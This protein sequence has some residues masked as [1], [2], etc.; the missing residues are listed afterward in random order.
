MQQTVVARFD[1]H[2]PWL[3]GTKQVL[4]D[5]VQIGCATALKNEGISCHWN[6]LTT[7]SDYNHSSKHLTSGSIL[8]QPERSMRVKPD[9]PEL[10]PSK[11][12]TAFNIRWS[13]FENAEAK[14][15]WLSQLQKFVS[16]VA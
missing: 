10:F 2:R 6:S 1:L 16:T 5:T 13:P 4:L 8:V 15:I 3:V 11:Q 7:D 9:L 12:L 14:L